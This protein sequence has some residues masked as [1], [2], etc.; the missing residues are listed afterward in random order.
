M[1]GILDT[2]KSWVDTGGEY[3]DVS[4]TEKA[5]TTAQEKVVEFAQKYGLDRLIPTRTKTVTKKAAAPAGAI[6]P[7]F[8]WIAG[9][10]SLGLL[11][12]YML[13]RKR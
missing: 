6:D 3:V 13:K 4:V 1:G 8:L 7:K 10:I 12:L 2:I 11:V 9:G 5:E